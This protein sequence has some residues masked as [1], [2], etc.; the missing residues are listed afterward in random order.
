MLVEEF[1]KNKLADLTPENADL[2]TIE[3]D[4]PLQAIGVNSLG[5]IKLIVEIEIQYNIQFPEDQLV[6][7]RA[8]T[9]KDIAYIT[10]QCIGRDVKNE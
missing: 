1:I 5:F 8:T 3:S 4:T 2:K 9:I 7:S 6:L 10:N